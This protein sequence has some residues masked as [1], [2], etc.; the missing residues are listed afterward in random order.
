MSPLT[1]T[2]P[3]SGTKPAV[4][5]LAAWLLN[6][7]VV[8]LAA[9]LAATPPLLPLGPWGDVGAAGAMGIAMLAGI[10]TIAASWRALARAGVAGVVALHVSMVGPVLWAA[11]MMDLTTGL[12]AGAI[13]HA[14]GAP[15]VAWLRTQLEDPKPNVCAICAYDLSGVP[16][17]EPTP[18]APK[19]TRRCPECGTVAKNTKPR[20]AS[21]SAP[22]ASRA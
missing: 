21:S 13:A 17:A 9:H 4:V 12:I 16:D 18:D 14:V 10:A 8:V 2:H 20:A 22:T 6:V 1:H 5:S 15:C 3:P 11:G 7:G 19:P